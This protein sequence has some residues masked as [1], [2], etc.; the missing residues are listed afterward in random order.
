MYL[1]R[2]VD[3]VNVVGPRLRRIDFILDPGDSWSGSNEFLELLRGQKDKLDVEI[4]LPSGHREEKKEDG[5]MMDEDRIME[6]WMSTLM[7]CLPTISLIIALFTLKYV[8]GP[9]KVW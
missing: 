9:V 4:G 3:L 8:V 1:D 6:L 2:L 5:D 7:S